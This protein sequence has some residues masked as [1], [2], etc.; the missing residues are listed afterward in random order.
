[1]GHHYK[2]RECVIQWLQKHQKVLWIL[3]RYRLSVW[4]GWSEEGW[5]RQETGGPSTDADT[6]SQGT[7]PVVETISPVKRT[8][9]EILV[10]RIKR[11][12]TGTVLVDHTRPTLLRPP[13]DLHAQQKFCFIGHERSLDV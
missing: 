1:M 5:E 4:K 8:L 3:Q 2:S 12:F 11:G 13:S 10:G 6:E 7:S 9:Q